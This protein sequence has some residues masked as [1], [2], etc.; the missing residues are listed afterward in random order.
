MDRND[1]RIVEV[2]PRDGL[3]NIEDFIATEHKIA[4]IKKLVDAGCRHIEVTSFVRPDLVPQMRDAQVVCE[5]LLTYPPAHYSALVANGVGLVRALASGVKEIAIVAAAS[6]TFSVRNIR[7]SI[8]ESIEAYRGIVA[9]A[10]R[11]DMVVRGYVSTAWWCPYEGRVDPQKVLDVATALFDLGVYEVSLADTIGKA[12]PDEVSQLL[13]VVLARHGTSCFALHMHDTDGNALANIE[14]GYA[15]GIR[16]FDSS[17]G[18]L[19]GCPFANVSVG[20]VATEDVVDCFAKS[21]IT[22]GIDIAKLVKASRYMEAVLGH[23]L[24]SRY[25]R[26]LK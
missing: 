22:T 3:Q 12:S 2:G 17:A 11:S 9:C 19:G 23:E 15:L 20:N 18:G 25:L 5:A 8:D 24:P 21:N 4:F 1:V 13:D 14:R 16:T 6:D 26:S 10:L 7:Q